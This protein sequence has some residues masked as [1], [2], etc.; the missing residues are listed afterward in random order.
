MQRAAA[1]TWAQAPAGWRNVPLPAPPDAP[2]PS[3]SGEL[4]VD[5]TLG[6][7]GRPVALAVDGEPVAATVDAAGP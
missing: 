2:S 7:D 3:T 6:R 1:T 4:L 5:L